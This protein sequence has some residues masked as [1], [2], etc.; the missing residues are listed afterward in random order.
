MRTVNVTTIDDVHR[1]LDEHGFASLQYHSP[2]H[3]KESS[4][5]SEGEVSRSRV[6]EEESSKVAI[7]GARGSIL[8]EAGLSRPGLTRRPNSSTVRP[9]LLRHAPCA[10]HQRHD[11]MTPAA[12][13]L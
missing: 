12:A 8:I 9:A 10:A 1:T 2:Q 4:S 13:S 6:R 11:V 5:Y 7:S 3:Q